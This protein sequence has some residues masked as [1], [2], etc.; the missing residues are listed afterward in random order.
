MHAADI[1]KAAHTLQMARFPLKDGSQVEVALMN[2]RCNECMNAG[3]KHG[4]DD[5]RGPVKR[6]QYALLQKRL[7]AL[8][9]D[10][11]SA[12]MRPCLYP[13]TNALF[14]ANTAGV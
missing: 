12:F 13:E 2:P 11:L 3:R 14:H 4:S 8:A 6:E 1:N 10:H 9:G 5:S 7:L